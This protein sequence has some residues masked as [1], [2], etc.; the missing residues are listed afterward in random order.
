MACDDG[1][2]THDGVRPPT[3]SRRAA[4]SS[5]RWIW[6]AWP[7]DMTIVS[8]T[9]ELPTPLIEV[10]TRTA[11]TVVDDETAVEYPNANGVLVDFNGAPENRYLI[12]NHVE[13]TEEAEPRSCY[14]V[15]VP[16][17]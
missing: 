10:D 9:F 17:L 3:L 4:P 12:T 5:V 11:Q 8:S 14:V 16:N 2:V 13:S 6:F 1:V 7:E 15:V